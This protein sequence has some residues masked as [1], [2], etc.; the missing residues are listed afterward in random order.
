MTT[1]HDEWSAAQYAMHSSLQEAMA[2]E[3]LALLHLQGSERVLDVGCGDGRISAQIAD[4]AASVLGVDASPDMVAHA[5]REYTA[6]GPQAR[7][8]LRFDVAD[9]RSLPFTAAFDCVVSF[10][11]LHWVHEP[12]SALRGIAAALVPAGHAQLR[13]VTRSD[14][15][16][17]EEAAEATRQQ[18]RWAPFFDA[19]DDPYLRLTAD[20]FAALAAACGLVVRTLHSAAKTWDFRSDTAF[21]GFCSAGFGAWTQRL[22]A[23]LQ[24]EFVEAVIASYRKATN[25][26]AADAN[27]FGFVQTDLA[28][29]RAQP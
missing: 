1:T 10:N 22:P 16:S 6:S 18:P 9:A 23:A 25:R 12:T 3:V 17:L 24:R 8:N 15:P 11:A 20:Q 21:F 19:F 7:G 5:N 4:R 27:V 28:L 13:L 26:G 29:Q 2:A 14:V